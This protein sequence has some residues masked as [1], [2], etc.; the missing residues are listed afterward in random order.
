MNNRKILTKGEWVHAFI[1]TTQN[2][3]I[4]LPV[5]AKI[6]DVKF[7]EFN[8]QYQIRI[9]KFY[10]NIHFLKM[11]LFGNHIQTSFSGATTRFKIKPAAHSTLESLMEN[12]ING[13]NWER[14]L[15]IVDSMFCTKTLNEQKDLFNK[16]QDFF[17]Q[18]KMKEIFELSNRKF[19]SSGRYHWDSAGN[20]ELSLKKFLGDKMPTEEGWIQDLLYRPYSNELDKA[21]R[22]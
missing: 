12:V 2:P 8:P 21:E 6:Y 16:L 19:Y 20:F 1:T 3:T 7:D 13:D 10:D 22:P 14:Y 11:F 18:E 17:I 15:V 9:H 4:L 5:K